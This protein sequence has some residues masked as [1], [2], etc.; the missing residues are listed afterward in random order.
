MVHLPSVSE[1][2][3]L[4]ASGTA[5]PR[6]IAAA[7]AADSNGG[8][9][10]DGR[11]AGGNS[12][13]SADW[14]EVL[15]GPPADTPASGGGPGGGNAGSGA[16]G[17]GA[18]RVALPKIKMTPIADP[19]EVPAVELP[20]LGRGTKLR[21]TPLLPPPTPPESRWMQSFKRIINP[22]LAATACGLVLG[23]SPLGAAAR[24]LP[25]PPEIA[26]LKEILS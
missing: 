14:P 4:E 17:D 12:L 20:L 2:R 16:D 6:T 21:G 7:P 22:P 11:D 3:R 13:A 26:W 25:T 23:L 19:N 18:G 24:T 15:Q 10:G 1:L 8:V 9:G 5:A